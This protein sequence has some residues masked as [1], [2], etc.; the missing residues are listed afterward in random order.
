M[1]AG[2]SRLVRLSDDEVRLLLQAFSTL[3]VVWGKLAKVAPKSLE[4]HQTR[5]V[6]AV[7]TS[8]A[9]NADPFLSGL[10]WAAVMSLPGEDLTEF[11]NGKDSD[12]EAELIAER[13]GREL[14]PDLGAFILQVVAESDLPIA[15][16]LRHQLD[17]LTEL[18]KSSNTRESSELLSDRD[19]AEIART[20]ERKAKIAGLAPESAR[21]IEQSMTPSAASAPD[22]EPSSAFVKAQEV[23]DEVLHLLEVAPAVAE[24]LRALAARIQSGHPPRPE[25]SDVL[26]Q[27]TEWI[28]RSTKVTDGDET[29]QR[30]GAAARAQIEQAMTRRNELEQLLQAVESLT[31]QGLDQFVPGLLSQHHFETIDTLRAALAEVVSAQSDPA[32]ARGDGHPKGAITLDE[33]TPINE[34]QG[35]RIGEGGSSG[36]RLLDSEAADTPIATTDEVAD[37]LF[38]SSAADSEPRLPPPAPRVGLASDIAPAAPVDGLCERHNASADQSPAPRA[39]SSSPPSFTDA[40]NV[41][42]GPLGTPNDRPPHSQPQTISPPD[43][44]YNLT[45]PSTDDR[46]PTTRDDSSPTV[47][48]APGQD[49][50]TNANPPRPKDANDSEVVP[51]VVRERAA[52]TQE[53]GSSPLPSDV[54][55]NGLI[56]SLISQ[57]RDPLA[58]L[59][60]EALDRHPHRTKTLRLFTGAFSSRSDVLLSQDPGLVVDDGESERTADEN[61]VLFAAHSRLALELGFSPVG[62]LDRF[63]Q[64]AA[65]EGHPLSDFATEVVRLTTRGFRRSLGATNLTA[66]PADW[67]RF[68]ESV[69]LKLESLR[70]LRIIYQRASRVIHHLARENQPIG[71]GLVSCSA[72]ARSAAIGE[73]PALADWTRLEELAI[74]LRDEQ[75]VER[76]L[77][78]T[79]RT[80]STAQQ[81][82]NPIVASSR[83]RLH[84]A[85]DDVADLLEEGLALRARSEGSG[86]ADDPQEMAALVALAGSAVDLPEGTVGAAALRRLVDWVQTDAMSAAPSS[87]L[88]QLLIEELLP[89][90][91]IGRTESGAPIRTMLTPSEVETLVEGRDPILVFRGYLASGNVRAA[92][93][94][95]ARY[96]VIRTPTS[97]DEIGEASQRLLRRQRELVAEADRV[98]DRLRSLFD[99]DLVRQLSQEL[100]E[101]RDLTPG[102]FD[103]HFEPLKTIQDRGEARLSEVRAGLRERAELLRVTQDSRRILHLLE[104][105]DEQ[106]A[107]DYLSLAEAGEPLPVLTPP[108][109]D[110]FGEFF[111]DVVSVA[112]MSRRQRDIDKIQ[113]VRT[114]LG[115]ASS[116]K[117]RMLSQGLKAWTELVLDK[118]ARQMTESRVAHVL[119]MLG[120]IPASQRWVKELT[121]ARHAGYATYAVKASPIDRSYVP[122][123]GTQAHGQYDVTIVWDEASPQRLLQYIET[124]R[125]T[126]A[127]VIL[128]LRTLAIDQR[129]ELRKLTNRPGF[130][131]SPIVIDMPVVAWLSTREEPAWRLTQRVTLPFTTLNPYTPFAGGEVPDEVFV[132]RDAERREIIDPTGSMFVYGGRQL[133]KSALLRRV[134]REIMRV[135][136]SSNESFEHGHVVVYLD[137]KS[138][139]IGES[140]APSALWGA[141]APRLVKAGVIP[142]Q[143]ESWSADTVTNGVLEWLESDISRRLLFLLDEADNFLTLD[144]RDTGPSQLGGFPVLQR[145]KG[146][147]ERTGRRFKPVFA[148]LHQVQR[149]HGL[150]NTP[151][152]HGGQDILIGPLK[153]VDARE[154]V[155][156]PL[157]ALGYEFE[158]PDTMWRLLRFTNYQASL[159][160]IICEALVR[161]MKSKSLGQERGRIV[162]TARDVDDVYS[163]REVRDLI[164]QRFRWTINLDNRYR[165][166]ALVTAL[167]SLDSRPG[168][169]FR[170]SDLHDECEYYWS[171][172]FAR[173]AL[174]SAEFFRYLN[175][176]Q[177]LGVLQRQG[178]EFG[179]R[180]PSILGLLGSRETIETELL[181]ASD[182]LEVGYQYNPTM[183]RR[184]LT[185]H[186]AG[187][188]TRSPLPDS[189]LAYLLSHS[190]GEPYVKVVAGTRALG[191][192]RVT[193]AVHRAAAERPVRVVDVDV[194]PSTLRDQISGADGTHL[195]LDLCTTDDAARRTALSVLS[196]SSETYVTVVLPASDIPLDAEKF[197][198]PVLHLRRWS[199]EGLQSWHDSPF[200]RQLLKDNTGGWPSLVEEAVSLVMRGASTENALQSIR[201]DLSNP[202]IAAE[203]LNDTS[204]PV[205]LAIQWLEWFA[206]ED[207]SGAVELTHASLDDLRTAFGVDAAHLIEQLQLLDVVDERPD[208]WVLDQAVASATRAVSG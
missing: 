94:V 191:L 101:H 180:S 102:R 43:E 122:S 157:Y 173:S 55:A 60:A 206:S 171:A 79:D 168:E 31:T 72:L 120:L 18:A 161:H 42:S 202:T 147:M 3:P 62:S 158:T 195:L 167:R 204:V 113:D 182:Q 32:H 104:S 139:G 80:L 193:N 19:T 152:V 116:P 85:V 200:S 164:A 47:T 197:D 127:N 41:K 175:E 154:L 44:P 54:W 144:A 38:T 129:L 91:E 140:A 156:D 10:A 130:A 149:F 69:D 177:G 52:E 57:S 189:D 95:V 11:P 66:L 205:A 151:V 109:G 201:A 51:R 108:G 159:I 146:M 141:I 97:E 86:S 73:R 89:L 56:A 70:N 78:D 23:L 64:G 207:S 49:S 5:T 37:S 150:P 34:P 160:Q 138:E 163:K 76:L 61:R 82:R 93:Q 136:E 190:K 9:R 115:A 187:E 169:R 203:F 98:L 12:E 148:G 198:W 26:Q 123:F 133:G 128:Y 183:N 39:E 7:R 172:G 63:R 194:E 45:D 103:L 181:E 81:S 36:A 24:N 165:V 100:E 143:N 135:R 155:R 192:E 107:V 15:E 142:P 67:Q 90:F 40:E 92:E 117:N 174:S 96:E 87:T 137:L 119:R 185:Q 162:I 166:I 48:V 121:K 170:S 29:L 8:L 71:E 28:S 83:D 53:L 208:G 106:L 27:A 74:K 59:A 4:Q 126:Q 132:G 21:V 17:V 99:D 145:L 30:V 25:A 20:S 75:Y 13:A 118:G 50:S 188:E 179:L 105:R 22:Y 65:L 125:R 178:D 35:E 16:R 153:P 46:P 58:V 184:V 68:A 33:K 176:M 88:S 196:E 77:S 186:S 199:L 84:T 114:H 134:E 1:N 14:G 112:T 2:R 6:R 110:D 111:P 124:N 131:F